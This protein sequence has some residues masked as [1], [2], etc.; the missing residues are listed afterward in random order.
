MSSFHNDDILRRL[1]VAAMFLFCLIPMA[2]SQ[3]ANALYLNDGSRIIGYVLQLD[4]AGDVR[5]RTT[6]GQMRVI[7]MSDVDNI[8][9]SYEIKPQGP[10]AIYRFGD[11]FR[12]KF[13]DVELTD[14]NYDKYFDDDLY[15]TYVG[16]S[17]QFNLGGACLVYG[18][19]CLVLSIL[20]FDPWS[21]KQT[22][23]FYA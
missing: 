6:E 11:K 8:N 13:S 3:S 19:T 7:P 14:S 1:T 17:N 12:W 20:E 4:S 5:V 15:H 18:V 2:F 21:D 10:G 16:G 23:S 22:D 9:W